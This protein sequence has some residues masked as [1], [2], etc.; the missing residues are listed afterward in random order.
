MDTEKTLLQQIREKEREYA[1]KIEEIKKET[2]LAV[3]TAKNEA[4]AGL[5]SADA[6]G[7]KEAEQLYWEGKGKIEAEIENLKRGAAAE[8]EAFAKTG[9]RKI[10]QAVDAI[11]GY[12][13]ME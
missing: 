10:S 11:N 4:E 1:V 5:C 9:E 13:T 6:A 2:T 8:R 7:K 12:I 3:E